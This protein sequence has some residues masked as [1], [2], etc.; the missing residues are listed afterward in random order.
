MRGGRKT[1]SNTQKKQKQLFVV[2]MLAPDI[3]KL[4]QKKKTQKK[5]LS[6]DDEFI[7]LFLLSKGQLLEEA[8]RELKQHKRRNADLQ[9]KLD[10]VTFT[11]DQGEKNDTETAEQSAI[12]V[13]LLPKHVIT[14]K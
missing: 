4:T 13:R 10:L 2:Q 11:E 12:Q 7:I 1:G 9:R 6:N 8:K 5:G 3:Y 14:K